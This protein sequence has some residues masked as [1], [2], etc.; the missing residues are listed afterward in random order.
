MLWDR[1][2]NFH[3]IAYFFCYRHLLF[4]CKKFS[5]RLDWKSTPKHNSNKNH[6]NKHYF[7]P[8]I[9]HGRNFKHFSTFKR[10]Q[11]NQD[12]TLGFNLT[13]VTL[14]LINPYKGKD[15]ILS[16]GSGNQQFT[17][18]HNIKRYSLHSGLYFKDQNDKNYKISFLFVTH[19][20]FK[21]T[22]IRIMF[23]ST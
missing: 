18:D 10:K 14:N 11:N 16:L 17:K 21:S 22:S 13:G 20:G 7:K 2:C 4:R 23:S 1:H 12:L 9:H 6:S 3:L 19:V 8:L 5:E 15:F